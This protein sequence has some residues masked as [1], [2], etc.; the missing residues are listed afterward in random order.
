MR[1]LILIAFLVVVSMLNAQT[2]RPKSIYASYFGETITHPGLKV[3]VTLQLHSWDKTKI[4]KSGI[5]KTIQKSVD[6][7]PSLGFFYHRGYQTG[8]FLLPELSYSRKNS[9]GNY[10][11]C[12]FGA[13]Y[14]RTFLPNVYDLNAKGEIERIHVG[15]NY[16]I[17]NYSITFGK[18]LSINKNIPMSIYIK[19]QLMYAI[20]NYLNGVGY[21]ALEFGV[22]YRLKMNE[23]K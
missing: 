20:P 21:F 4:K 14:M 5:E 6:V 10:L 2:L 3:G 7:S 17:T 13:G 9:K 19:P 1:Y 11:T 18:D 22:N 15:Y 8:A 23:T 12:A 16:F